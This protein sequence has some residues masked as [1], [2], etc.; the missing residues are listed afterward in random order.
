MKW[1]VMT[2]PM[3]HRFT[4]HLWFKGSYAKYGSKVHMRNMVQSLH[5]KFTLFCTSTSKGHFSLHK[6]TSL[7]NEFMT[8]RLQLFP[9]F[10]EEST[11]MS[12]E[13][14]SQNAKF[15]YEQKTMHFCTHVLKVSIILLWFMLMRLIS[16]VVLT[17]ESRE[18]QGSY[19]FWFLLS[20]YQLHSERFVKMLER[21]RDSSERLVVILDL[22]RQD[23]LKES[24]I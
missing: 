11:L 2:L 15:K 20:F 1:G 12:T 7:I 19:W 21:F 9:L 5:R 18:S 24:N 22:I 10:R 6:G 14:S 17:W 16:Q 3:I 23:N 8:V 13:K 4:Y